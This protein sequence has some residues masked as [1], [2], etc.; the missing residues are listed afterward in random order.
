MTKKTY[1]CPA[2]QS[3]KLGAEGMIATS[4]DFDNNGPQDGLQGDTNGKQNR[5]GLTVTDW[6][7]ED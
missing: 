3:L 7:N 6:E 2:C 1:V 5:F 4:L